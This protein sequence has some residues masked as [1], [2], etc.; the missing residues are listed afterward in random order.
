MTTSFLPPQRRLIKKFSFADVLPITHSNATGVT[1][2]TPLFDLQAGTLK[3]NGVLRITISGR[4]FN[5][6]TPCFF[7]VGLRFG[8]Q[9]YVSG[10]AQFNPSANEW[11]F[12]ANWEIHGME[13]NSQRF[14]GVSNMH[15]GAG[16]SNSLAVNPDQAF[17][18]DVLAN[19]NIQ[20]LV[21]HTH[22]NVNVR[23]TLNAF[24]I[25]LE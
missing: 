11:I 22:A 19:K 15:E 9:D 6:V 5:N 2:I 17:N 7:R 24:R 8:S 23:F 20:F 21:D 4:Y 3:R 25:D 12:N 10:F 16:L 18:Q 1:A 13:V 14:R